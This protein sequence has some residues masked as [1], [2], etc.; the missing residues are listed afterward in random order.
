MKYNDKR[1]ARG[2]IL[3]N[4]HQTVFLVDNH[5][6]V[7]RLLHVVGIIWSCKYPD[8]STH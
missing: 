8:A 6:D 2:M 3:G 7:L 5:C 1:P 4:C